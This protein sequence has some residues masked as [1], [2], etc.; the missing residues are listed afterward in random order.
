MVDFV[1]VAGEIA[2]SLV[3]SLGEFSF[4]RPLGGS[5]AVADDCNT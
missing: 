3:E 5:W 4:Y 2:P 1:G